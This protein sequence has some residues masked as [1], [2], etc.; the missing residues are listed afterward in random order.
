MLKIKLW[1]YY[2]RPHKGTV[3]AADVFHYRI[4]NV[5]KPHDHQRV[6]KDELRSA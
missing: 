4:K 5:N 6:A 2:P 1:S 3:R